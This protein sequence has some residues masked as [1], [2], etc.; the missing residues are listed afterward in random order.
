MSIQDQDQN[1]IIRLSTIGALSL[2]LGSL[3]LAPVLLLLMG[4]GTWMTVAVFRHDSEIARLDA[5]ISRSLGNRMQP[6]AS[7][8]PSYVRRSS[9]PTNELPPRTSE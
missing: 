2:K 8:L 5:I 1:E 4:W 9:I 7:E 6:V 3:L